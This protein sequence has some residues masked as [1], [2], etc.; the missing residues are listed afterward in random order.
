MLPFYIYI[1]I[2]GSFSFVLVHECSP[3]PS[4]PR[5]KNQKR[6]W[7]WNCQKRV[8][9]RKFFEKIEALDPNINI[10]IS[11]YTRECKKYRKNGPKKLYF[12][13]IWD[14]LY[15]FL[16]FKHKRNCHMEIFIFRLRASMIGLWILRMTS[17]LPFRGQFHF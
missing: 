5:A 11:K 7:S 3:S 1:D 12:F 4:L 8:V 2:C 16:L 15:I 9:F 6:N 17:F 14:P 10:L 13:L